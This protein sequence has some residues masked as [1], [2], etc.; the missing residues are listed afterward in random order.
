VLGFSIVFILLGITTSAIGMLLYDARTFLSKIGGIIVVIFGLHMIGVFL[1]PFPG[2]RYP[3]AG[4]GPW[5]TII[6]P[7]GCFSL[8]DG[9]H[10]WVGWRPDTSFNGGSVSQG[11]SSVIYSAG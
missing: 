8:P 1:H 5:V 3:A 9:R 2:I 10:A 7:M 6:W 11:E 4:R